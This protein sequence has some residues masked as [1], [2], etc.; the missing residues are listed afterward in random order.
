MN[1]ALNKDNVF[2]LIKNLMK[3]S[4]IQFKIIDLI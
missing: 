1:F 4:K 2:N 3:Q